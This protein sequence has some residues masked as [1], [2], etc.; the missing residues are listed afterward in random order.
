VSFFVHPQAICESPTIGVGTRVWAFSHILPGARLGKD[1][2]ICDHTFIENDVVLGDRVTVKSGVHLWDGL[3]VEDDVFIGPNATFANDRFPRSKRRP[4]TFLVTTLRAGASIG[5]NATILPGITV[6]RHAMVGAGAVVIESVPPHSIVAG[7]PARIVGHCDAGPR[8]TPATRRLPQR[9]A[10]SRVRG[11]FLQQ[12]S[13]VADLRGSLVAAELAEFLPFAVKRF[14]LVHDVPG[15]EVRGQHAHKTC[16]QLLVCVRG[17]C[18]VIA[19]DGVRRQEFLLDRASLGLYIPPKVWAAQFDYSPDAELL[20]L[21]SHPY[22]A[23]DYIRDY[24]EFLRH[25]RR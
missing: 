10:K 12:L 7:N 22:D 1:C 9:T 14:F 8:P 18:R 25:V 20:V 13:S 4:R 2:N 16:H 17:S 3:R 15:R 11:V 19:D 6:G 23:A 24:D 21:A 5:A